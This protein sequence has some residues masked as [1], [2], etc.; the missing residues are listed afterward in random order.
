MPRVERSRHPRIA[1][2]V[3]LM[4]SYQLMSYC[5]YLDSCSTML[6]GIYNLNLCAADSQAE[7]TAVIH[8]AVRLGILQIN[9]S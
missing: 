1:E 4:L 5:Y 6:E 7:V 8:L 2:G 3:Y 9:S